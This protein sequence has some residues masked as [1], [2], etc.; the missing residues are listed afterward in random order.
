MQETLQARNREFRSRA[1]RRTGRGATC[2]GDK[3]MHR[4]LWWIGPLCALIL[5]CGSCAKE[6]PTLNLLVWEGYADPSFV[7]GFEEQCKCQ[8]AASYMGSIDKLV[9][10]LRGVRRR[11]V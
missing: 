2:G 9:A 8:V 1:N 7:K 5:F 11:C 3:R 6:T 4:R 10:K